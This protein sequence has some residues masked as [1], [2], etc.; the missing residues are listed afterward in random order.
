M[1]TMLGNWYARIK[2]GWKTVGAAGVG[3]FDYGQDW[4]PTSV[5]PIS[6]MKLSAYFACVRLLYADT[7]PQAGQVR[8]VFC[9]GTAISSPPFQASL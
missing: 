6:A 9:G 8:L 7:W 1:A 3:A 2:G 4:V 5:G